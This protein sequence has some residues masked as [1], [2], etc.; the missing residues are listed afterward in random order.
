MFKTRYRIVTDAHLGY[1][2]QM[3]YWWLPF[4]FQ[5][6]DGYRGCNTHPSIERAE[7]F[8][9]KHF[10]KSSPENKPGQVV[11]YVEPKNENK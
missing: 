6:S 5:L 9:Q 4:W 11:K 2:A 7:A 3:R 1:E 10:H 8:I